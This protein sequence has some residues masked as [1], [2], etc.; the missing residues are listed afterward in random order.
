MRDGC[1]VL[2]RALQLQ[3]FVSISNSPCS[4]S[5]ELLLPFVIQMLGFFC[6]CIP[7]GTTDCSV[8]NVFL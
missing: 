5:G 2:H 8:I 1:R 7:V 3:T 6:K 4:E